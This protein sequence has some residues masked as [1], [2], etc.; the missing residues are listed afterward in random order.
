VGRAKFTLKDLLAAG[1]AKTTVRDLLKTS[2]IELKLRSDVVP[3]KRQE[4]DTT[5]NLDLNTTAKKT[6]KTVEKASPYYVNST[7][8]VISVNLARPIQ[9]F[10]EKL[11]LN[12]YKQK[13]RMRL[14][15]EWRQEE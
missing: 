8:A 14:D 9:E 4:V 3:L 5:T 12:I 6:E 11:E 2:C 13:Y 7:Y 1:K 10:N 15:R